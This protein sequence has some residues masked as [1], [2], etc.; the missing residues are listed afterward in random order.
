M[1][2]YASQL[3]YQNRRYKEYDIAP[4]LRTFNASGDNWYKYNAT[5]DENDNL[6]CYR[7]R[8]LYRRRLPRKVSMS[9]VWLQKNKNST[10]PPQVIDSNDNEIDF[11][12]AISSLLS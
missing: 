11:S 7:A 8:K 2:V 5:L 1:N 9:Q 12:S 4:Q 10:E 3:E 6:C